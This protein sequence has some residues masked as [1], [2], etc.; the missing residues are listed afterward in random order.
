[1][2]VD[3]AAICRR[4]ERMKSARS[5]IET[6]IRDC[7]RYTDPVRGTA[8]ENLGTV[9]IDGGSVAISNAADKRADLLTDVGTESA[10][11]HAAALMSGMV[12]A[13][14]MW[15]GLDVPDAGD[16]EKQ[17]L[18]DA[19]KAVWENIHASNFDAVA[20]DCMYDITIAGQFA[21]FVDEADDG[22]Y[23]FEQWALANTYFSSSRNGGPV[24][25]V[26]NEYPLTAEQAVM[27]YGEDMVSEQVRKAYAETPDQQF[28]FIRAIFPR[29]EGNGRMAKN[30][31]IASMHIEQ[32]TKHVCR[33]SGYHEMPV[34]VPR[35]KLLTGSHYALGPVYDA[36][37]SLKTLN[38]AV[39][40]VLANMD[41][42]VAGMWIAEDDGVLNP[43]SVRVG[44]R[45]II[46]ANS[47]DSMKALQP[48][49][50]FDAAFLQIDALEKQIRRVLMADQLTPKDG[51]AITATEATIN[52]EL[53]R[54]Q[55]GPIYGRMKS[56]FLQWLVMRCF[57]IA[58]RAG[59]LG[60]APPAIRRSMVSV[61]YVSPIARAQRAV[62]VAAMDRYEL[63]LGQAATVR[64]EVLDNYDWDEAER[65]RAELLGV[66]KKLTVEIEKRDEMRAQRQQAAQQAQQQQMLAGA[67]GAAA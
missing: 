55:L 64:P 24:D 20:F 44:P 41:L 3:A 40:M 31:P 43:R 33:E 37:P 8:F 39:E 32:G 45:K 16:A 52:V 17:W 65:E 62:E 42:A 1:M 30:M 48:A 6:E 36:L 29:H 26:I 38:K 58:Y 2:K 25:T 53:I 13:N 49:A 60:L 56:E 35:W 10:R 21:M 12:P 23:R 61:R 34:G 27:A 63:S 51:P 5:V 57:G 15:F 54:Q 7:Y 46:I 4:L 22:G 59:A 11:I 47:V 50:K 19:A 66:P 14:S 18:E 67:V 9:P 28:V